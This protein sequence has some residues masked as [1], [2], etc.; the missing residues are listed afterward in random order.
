M[1]FLW[2]QM[3]WLLLLVPA[4][5]AAYLWLLSRRKVAVRYASLSLVREA[6]GRGPGWRRHLPP[7]LLLGALAAALMA[8]ARP[9]AV[10]TLPTQ[11]QTIML[12]IDVSL[13][14]RA[15]DVLPDRIT[16][17]QAAAK[18]FIEDHPPRARIGL[19][20]FGGSAQL[21][22][23]PTERTDDLIA[24]ID[25]FQLQRGTA[26]GSALVVALAALFPDDGIDVESVVFGRA[27]SRDG[28]RGVP[29]DRPAKAERP[30]PAPVK[31]GSHTSGVIVLLSDGRR[32][33]GPDPIDVAR[34][35]AD[36]GVRVFTVGFGTLEGATIGFEG[37]SAYVRLDE[38]ALK[39]V[40]QI[41]HG[42]YFH[43]GTAAD[44]KKVYQELNTRFVM[45]RKE[46][47]V[48]GLLSALA[49]LLLAGAGALSLAWFGRHVPA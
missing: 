44:L 29:I 17:A 28:S 41:T 43:A 48:T 5:V 16:A 23:K 40:A 32:T 33:T 31:P 18:T 4:S 2:P 36:R 8:I 24:A 10:V 27:G 12:A 11:Y 45:E 3:L 14:M 34:M 1:S 21:V 46:T 42:E 19:V 38:E 13:S 6:A 7:L 26:T 49:A 9:T 20:A 47:E 35:A 39:A 37:W 22:Q 25:R 15:T 30:P